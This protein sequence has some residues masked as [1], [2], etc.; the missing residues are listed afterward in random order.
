MSN[1]ILPAGV[2]IFRK[3]S[4]A[5]ILDSTPRQIDSLMDRGLLAYC[6]LEEGPKAERVVK[7]ADLEAFLIRIESTRRV[8]PAARITPQRITS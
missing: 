6:R 5:R 7:R 1:P 8:P 3:P 4:L 2:A